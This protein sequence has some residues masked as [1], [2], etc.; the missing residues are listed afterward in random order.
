MVKMEF[1]I[2]PN[3]RIFNEHNFAVLTLNNIQISK[4]FF[5]FYKENH[6][7]GNLNEVRKNSKHYEDCKCI[8]FFTGI[9]LTNVVRNANVEVIE[10]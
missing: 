4:F 6:R 1:D 10:G 8:D 7:D 5:D 2:V 3:L 9:T